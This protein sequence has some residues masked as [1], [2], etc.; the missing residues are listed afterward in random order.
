MFLSFRPN[1]G[2]AVL[3]MA[4]TV[5]VIIIC[6]GIVNPVKATEIH[7]IQDGVKLPIIMYHSLLKESARQGDYIISPDIFEKDLKY[8]EANGYT[9]IVMQDLI[10]YVNKDIPLPVKPVMLTFDDGYY[11]NYYYAFPIVKKHRAKIV[12]SPI[13]YYT[14]LFT[15]SDPNHPNYSYCTWDQ[16]NEMK[17]SGLVE[18]QNHTYN[19]HSSSGTR[20]GAKKLKNESTADYVDLL[21][22]DLS[23]M[24]QKMKEQTGYIPTTFVYPFGAVSKDSMPVIK[25][26]GFQASLTCRKKIN[27]ITK[28]PNCLYC[29]GRFLR[30]A[31]SSSKNFFSK[32]DV[33]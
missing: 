24:Q 33:K 27:Y 22:T 25:S 19:L 15:G 3:I 20:L 21:R 29:L 8:L 30:P 32:I 6:C 28:N 12:I 26:L 31:G 9:T 11:N 13:G 17:R 4:V 18:I 1:K 5:T 10:N 16:I 2:I 7:T 14:D 23:K